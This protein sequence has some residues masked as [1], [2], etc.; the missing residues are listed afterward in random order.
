MQ[1]TNSWSIA[2]MGFLP[3]YKPRNFEP[4][5]PHNESSTGEALQQA[6]S[7]QENLQKFEFPCWELS[8][9]NAFR[10]FPQPAILVRSLSCTAHSYIGFSCPRHPKVILIHLHIQLSIYI[11][12]FHLTHHQLL[13]NY[14]IILYT[15]AELCYFKVI[16]T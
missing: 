4:R 5:N 12:I 1:E 2:G 8:M 7:P 11:Y 15:L 16:F 14:L 3:G 6:I 9:G 13:I 10:Y